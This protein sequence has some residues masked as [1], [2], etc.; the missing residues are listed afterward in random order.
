MDH[1]RLKTTLI[2]VMILSSFILGVILLVGQIS[3]SDAHDF[4]VFYTAASSSLAGKSI[5][6]TTGKYNLPFWYFPWTAWLFIPLALFP[7][8]VAL[9]IYQGLSIVSAALSVKILLRH[10]NPK[11]EIENMLVIYTGL[12][13]MSLELGWVGQMD[14]IVLGFVVLII[15]GVENNKG[16]MVGVLYPFLLTKPHLFIPFT[17]FLFLRAQKRS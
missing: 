7:K 3:T 6:V 14:Y 2:H 1:I 8:D 12:I 9:L 15:W 5:Y 16:I 4:N 11:F 17:L 10:Y 13:L